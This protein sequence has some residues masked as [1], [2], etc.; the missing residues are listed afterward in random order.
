MILTS[1][2]GYNF[3]APLG[4]D[5]S[6]EEIN[7]PFLVYSNDFIYEKGINK[8]FIEDIRHLIN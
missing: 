3:K 7:T 5:L 2:H 6:K 4:K 8:R 1:D